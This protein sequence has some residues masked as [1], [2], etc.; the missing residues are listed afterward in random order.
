MCSAPGSPPK[1]TPTARSCSRRSRPASIRSRPSRPPS[2][3]AASTGS[4]SGPETS[5][6][7]ACA[8][9][10]SRRSS[11]SSWSPRA[12][13]GSSTS[14]PR[15]ASSSPARRSTACRT[16]PTICSTPSSASPA[17]R[18]TTSRRAFNIR[19]GGADEILVLLDGLE[20]IEPF[21]LKD[22]QSVFSTVDA[23]AV[24]GVDL[25]TGGYP[26]EYGDRM[27]GVMDIAIARAQRHGPHHHR[28]RNAELASRSPRGGSTMG[29]ASGW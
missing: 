20:L 24:G 15:A 10:A 3:P 8:W 7:C 13:S 4:G 21:H 26:V 14:S 11:A 12:T 5:P 1:P 27:S 2:S 9:S 18:R 17:R 29:V 22:F 23:N 28:R 16:W 6:D 19:G 25:L